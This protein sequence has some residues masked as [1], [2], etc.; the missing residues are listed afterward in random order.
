M[1]RV[2]GTSV[3][4]T[5]CHVCFKQMQKIDNRARTW[6][7]PQRVGPPFLKKGK[8][9]SLARSAEKVWDIFAHKFSCISHEK[10]EKR[11]KGHTLVLFPLVLGALEAETAAVDAA[12][13]T[14]AAATDKDG[15]VKPAG[16]DVKATPSIKVAWVVAV[17]ADIFGL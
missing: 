10:R 11:V 17:I 7:H 6:F 8:K 15:R 16:M 5:E 9:R 3:T 4:H 1:P 14:E 2:H 12:D 13:A